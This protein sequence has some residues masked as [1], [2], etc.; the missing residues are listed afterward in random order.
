MACWVQL[1]GESEM[2]VP[3][4]EINEAIREM[5]GQETRFFTAQLGIFRTQVR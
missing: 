2:K 1:G 5:N 4:I 3:Q